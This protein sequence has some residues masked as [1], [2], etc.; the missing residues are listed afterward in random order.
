MNARGKNVGVPANGSGRHVERR[1]NRPCN[2]E[3]GKRDL[4]LCF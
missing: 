3:F 4:G 2:A 1:H